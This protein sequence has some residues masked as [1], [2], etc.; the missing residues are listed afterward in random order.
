MNIWQL[1]R[2]HSTGFRLHISAKRNAVFA[3]TGM[4]DYAIAESIFGSVE[5]FVSLGVIVLI[6]VFNV[7]LR[8]V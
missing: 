4:I 2:I 3:K 8:K 7:I 6:V 1:Y 5:R